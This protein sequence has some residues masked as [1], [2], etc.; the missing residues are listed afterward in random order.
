MVPLEGK[1]MFDLRESAKLFSKILVSFHTS[2]SCVWGFQFLH[3]LIN[4]S[5]GQQSFSIL[6]IV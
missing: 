5:Y 2:T 6:G 3:S 1:C 4:T